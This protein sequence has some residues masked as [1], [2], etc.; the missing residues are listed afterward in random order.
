VT[1]QLIVFEGIEGAGKTT[2]LGILAERLREAGHDVEWVREPG[3]TPVGDSIRQL[4]LDPSNTMSAGSEALL[5]M[6]SRAELVTRVIN[7]A[8][9]RGSIV[10]AD[11]FFLSTYAYQIAGRGLPEEEVRQAN[12]LA[13]RGLIPD[14]TILLDVSASDGL[15]RVG[16]RGEHDRIERSPDEFHQ[17]VRDAFRAFTRPEWSAAHPEAGP[18]ALIDGSG[19]RHEV[20]ARVLEA[21]SARWP[22]TFGALAGSH[23]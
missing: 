12:E 6:A 8:L 19:E 5:F 18:I 13:T 23:H 4:L 14:L 2:Q 3:G 11:R 16:R 17:R 1:G 15:G 20:A 7:P 10:L 21:L 9:A 22:R